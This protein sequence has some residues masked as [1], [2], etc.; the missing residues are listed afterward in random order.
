MSNRV[1][2]CWR[3]GLHEAPRKRQ[4]ER[5]NQAQRHFWSQLRIS[6][7]IKEWQ[8][9]LHRE[10]LNENRQKMPLN[11]LIYC[12]KKALLICP[13]LFTM[14]NT[15]TQI[16]WQ[17]RRLALEL[18]HTRDGP[19]AG[20]SQYP[21]SLLHDLDKLIIWIFMSAVAESFQPRDR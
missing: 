11:S 7:S 6:L 1:G 17:I 5:T 19:R 18:S 16:S 9:V 14:P 2:A 10:K 3:G 21:G 15:F 4:G 20:P 8:L 13:C 12:G